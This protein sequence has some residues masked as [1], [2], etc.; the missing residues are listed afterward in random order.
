MTIGLVTL[1]KLFKC[2]PMSLARDKAFFCVLGVI[3]LSQ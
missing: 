2:G 3:L 1:T